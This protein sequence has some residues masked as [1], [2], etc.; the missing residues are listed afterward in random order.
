[1][2][3]IIRIAAFVLAFIMAYQSFDS[4]RS[5]FTGTHPKASAPEKDPRATSSRLGGATWGIISLGISLT[6]FWIAFHG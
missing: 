5:A 6:F 3:D 4:L 2:R 1:M